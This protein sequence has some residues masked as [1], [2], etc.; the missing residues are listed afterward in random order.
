MNIVTN[1][2]VIILLEP[3]LLLKPL[4][5]IC[6]NLS[7]NLI[8]RMVLMLIGPRKWNMCEVR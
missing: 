3:S 5:S 2:S 7:I 1:I 8:L 6:Q 4:A